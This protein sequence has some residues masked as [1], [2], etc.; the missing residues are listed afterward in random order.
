M[1]TLTLPCRK[2]ATRKFETVSVEQY[3]RSNPPITDE[4]LQNPVK[5]EGPSWE[6]SRGTASAAEIGGGAAGVPIAKGRR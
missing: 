3:G 6:R 1:E 4:R 5:N 2:V